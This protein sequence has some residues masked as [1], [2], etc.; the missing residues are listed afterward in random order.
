M[1]SFSLKNRFGRRKI[2]LISTVAQVLVGIVTAFSPSLEIYAL[3][4]LLVGIAGAAQFNC[5]YITG[6]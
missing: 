3:L 2:L 5:A 1:N 4:R 6:D